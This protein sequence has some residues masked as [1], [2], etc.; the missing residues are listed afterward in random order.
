MTRIAY[1][2]PFNGCSG[3]MT[4]GS[5]VDAGLCLD[6]LRKG[7][8]GLDLDGYSIE[9]EKVLRGAFQCTR[10]RVV[11]DGRDQVAEKT[12]GHQHSHEHNHEHS[13]S[14]SHSHSHPGSTP[15]SRDADHRSLGAITSLIEASSL[16]QAVVKNAK[17]VFTR[18]GEVEAGVHGVDIEDVHFHEVGAVD[19]IV[20]IVGSCLAL[21][22]LGIEE[23]YCAPITVGTGFVE[24]A[25]GRMPLPAPA[26]ANLLRGF[27]IR[28]VDSGA[29][30]TTPTGAA[31][32]TTLAKDFGTMPPLQVTATGFG[33]GDE[34]Q[35]AT[36]NALR[37]FLGELEEAAAGRDRVLLLETNIDDMS[38]EWIGHLMDRLLE[39]GA[40]DV[41]V[42]PILMKKSRPAHKLT[43][44]APLERE[45]EITH[46]LFC[47]STTIG[48][49]RTETERVVLER[50]T[51]EI[52]APWGKIRIKIARHGGE[53]VG[54]SPE[55]EDLK[56]AAASSGL[57]LKELH[58]LA[59]EIFHRGTE[60]DTGEQS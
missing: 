31:L 24:G 21:E 26:T 56:R 53:Q 38:S 5:L 28:Q 22:L 35:G 43:I 50:E 1:F 10:V 44:L 2:Q 11:V 48:V 60:A 47:E 23:V 25:H 36:P 52:E 16:P 19:S 37:V 54:A 12:P 8:L 46:T 40:L 33:A 14:H 6:E 58:R 4:L 27:P 7:L 15:E 17:A 13:H 34:R 49:R 3:D 57:P 42:S 18:L 51:E 59:L 20:D 55:F 41:S 30:L 29:E 39:E 9:E 32:M 45:Q